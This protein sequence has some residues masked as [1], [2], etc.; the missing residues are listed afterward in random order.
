MKTFNHFC[1]D[2]A[3]DYEAGMRAFKSSPAQRLAA[4]REEEG[5]RSQTSA[6]AFQQRLSDQTDAAKEKHKK[7][8]QDYEERTSQNEDLQNNHHQWIQ[9]SITNR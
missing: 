3:R 2:A 4:R 9:V 8:R 6:S 7:M 5:N 1:E